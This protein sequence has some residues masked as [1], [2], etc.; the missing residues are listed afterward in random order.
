MC[1]TW[2]ALTLRESVSHDFKAVWMRQ[3]LMCA[4]LSAFQINDA[5]AF[6]EDGKSVR[7]LP[8]FTALQSQMENYQ[9]VDRWLTGAG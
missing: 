3:K 9:T 2:M 6:N 4:T 8:S 1:I 7:K 5:I